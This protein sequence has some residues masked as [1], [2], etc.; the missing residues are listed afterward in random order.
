MAIVS[1]VVELKDQPGQLLR[2]LEPISRL[3]GNILSIVHQRDKKTPLGR[4]PVEISLQIDEKKV[5]DLI[6]IIKSETIVRSYNEVRL[7]ATTSIMLVG[8]II[9]TDLG[10]TINSIDR[11]GFA[12][13]VDMHI[14]MPKLNEPSTA[15]VTISATGKEKLKEAIE[16]LRDVCRRKG[17]LMIEPLNEEPV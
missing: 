10:D 13:V 3:G 16:L 9:H 5:D 14:S 12:E 6:K 8:H 4:I 15:M 7:I 11:T 17:I 2:V 1:I